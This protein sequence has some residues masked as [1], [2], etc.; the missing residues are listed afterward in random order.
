MRSLLRVGVPPAAACARSLC[1]RAARRRRRRSRCV[2]GVPPLSTCFAVACK[3]VAV[4]PLHQRQV[5][6]AQHVAV[7]VIAV[8]IGAVGLGRLPNRGAAQ[9][10]AVLALLPC[11]PRSGWLR[12]R[13]SCASSPSLPGR[14]RDV[15]HL[16]EVADGVVDVA[17]DVGAHGVAVAGV[18]QA[19]ARRIVVAN[20][21]SARRRSGPGARGRWL[22]SA[23]RWR[24]RCSRCSARRACC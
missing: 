7:G 17:L 14:C 13:R 21:G 3:L 15:L 12:C 16:Q 24:R 19:D 9:A 4:V 5:R 2:S 18:Q 10:V 11:R 23:G 8:S 1:A 20:A 22:R 6:H